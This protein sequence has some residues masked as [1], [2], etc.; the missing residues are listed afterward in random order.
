VIEGNLGDF[1]EFVLDGTHAS[2]DRTETGVPVLSAQNVKD[3]IL[4]FETDRHTSEKEYAA[5][6]ARLHVKAGDVLLTIVGSIGRAAVLS[7]VRPFVLQRSV[8][9]IRPNC[10]LLDSRF[11]FQLLRSKGFQNQLT[12]FTN[13]SSQAGIYLGKLKN[14]RIRIP[15]LTEQRRI[16]DILDHA[17]ALRAKRRIALA[18]LGTLIQAIFLD[19]FGNPVTNPKAWP[20]RKL[21]EISRKITDGEHLNPQSA[22]DGVPIVMAGNVLEDFVDLDGCKVVAISM[23]QKYRKKCDPEIGDLLIVSRGATIGRSC[24]VNTDSL[25]CLMGS[26]ILLKVE[27]DLVESRY[28]SAV[29]KHPDMQHRLYG[30]SGSS[31][32]QA[33]YLKDLK[34]F[35]CPLPPLPL[36]QEFARRVAAI[37]KLKAVHRASLSE[38][39]AL[40]AS[41]QHRAFRGEL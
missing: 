24:I 19:V 11:L 40:F 36:Q 39:D 2:P 38:M 6:N 26:V 28:L 7:E 16:A 32:Q 31:A 13:Q 5:F 41:L 35:V 29:L 8:A 3:G 30:T 15:P 18:Q 4:N 33:I 12:K 17:E 25:F 10:G 27:K 34:K 21:E 23:G 9:V 20:Y 14:I 1:S 37:E 22:E